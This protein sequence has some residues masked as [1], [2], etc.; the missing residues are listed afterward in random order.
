MPIPIACPGC[1]LTENG[2]DSLKGKRVRCKRCKQGF[3]VGGGPEYYSF[4]LGPTDARDRFA[5]GLALARRAWS[6]SG[7]FRW[8][9]RYY[10]LDCVNPWPIPLQRPHPP[11]WVCG[12]GSPS[13]LEMCA[14]EDLGYMGVNTNTGHRDFINSER[15]LLEQS[16]QL[17]V[18]RLHG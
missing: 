4:A 17:Y 6:E 3:V 18:D 9:G 10:Q 7:P 13:T 15:R 12:V 14:R 11:I 2:P 5:E 8:D 1:G 16:Y